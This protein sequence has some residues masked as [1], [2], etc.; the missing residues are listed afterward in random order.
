MSKFDTL[1]VWQK[2]GSWIGLSA[3][4]NVERMEIFKTEI[5]NVCLGS[6][7]AVQGSS[8]C[9]RCAIR[10]GNSASEFL[11]LDIKRT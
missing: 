8:A 4:R 5:G 11:E 3:K 2:I 9:V 7:A 10:S 6:E 1:S